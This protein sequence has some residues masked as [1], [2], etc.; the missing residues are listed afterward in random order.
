[1]NPIHQIFKG[2]Q[3][4]QH[5]VMDLMGVDFHAEVDLSAGFELLVCHKGLEVPDP[6]GVI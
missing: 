2:H 4:S 3:T 5:L 6:K 1:M